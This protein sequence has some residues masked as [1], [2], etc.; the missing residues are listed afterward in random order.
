MECPDLLLLQLVRFARSDS[1]RSPNQCLHSHRKS[2]PSYFP[3]SAFDG[4]QRTD[5]CED[6]PD[7]HWFERVGSRSFLREG[8]RRHIRGPA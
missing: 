2:T 8:S 5:R 1:L 3:K 4:V 7:L 6:I